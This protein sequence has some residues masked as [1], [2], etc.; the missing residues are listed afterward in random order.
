MASLIRRS[1][2]CWAGLVMIAALL[3]VLLPLAGRAVTLASPPFPLAQ[4]DQLLV[5]PVALPDFDPSVN[6]FQFS[7]AEMS[8]AINLQS[9]QEDW[10]LVLTDQ[11]QQLFGTQVC[12]GG[13]GGVGCVLTAAAQD[14]LNNQLNLMQQ[15]VGE[16][17]AAATLQLWQPQPRPVIP[18]WQALLNFILR[19]TVF[20]L[21]RN[22]FDLQTFIANLFLLQHV[23]QVARPTQQIRDSLTPTQILQEI[24]RA[25]V[26]QPTD[27]YTMGLYR[28]RDNRLTD[29]QSLTPYKVEPQPDGQYWV[30]VYDSNYPAGRPNGPKFTY[31]EFNPTTDSWTYQPT[32]T[33]TPIQGDATS[34]N[35]DL[36]KLSW[37]LPDVKTDTPPLKGPFTCPFCEPEPTPADVQLPA[38]Q[39]TIALIGEGALQVEQWD[40]ATA[41]YQPGLQTITGDVN[42]VPFKGGLDRQVPARYQLSDPES[43]QPLRLTVSGKPQAQTEDATLAITGPGYTASFEQ[44]RLGPND[45]LSLFLVPATT[46]PQITVTAPQAQTMPALVINLE[47]FSQNYRFD[48]STPASFAQTERRVSK[49]TQFQIGGLTLPADQQVALAVDTVQKRFYFGDTTANP[50]TYQ[51]TVKNVIVVQDRIQVGERQPDFINYTLSYDEALRLSNVTVAPQTQAFFDYQPALYDPGEKSRDQILDDLESRHI[52]V[53]IG[54]ISTNGIT[55]AD[56]PIVFNLATASGTARIYA[57]NLQ[58]KAML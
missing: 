29:G 49:S 37:R 39:I 19:R 53:P 48:S 2:W 25:L 6:G 43:N 16:G 58:L 51:V 4:A 32:A 21:A 50:Q 14:W 55:A 41:Q 23:D 36:S 9:R 56:G 38:D 45:Q 22:L 52:D 11:L 33:S 7:N 42:L 5:E 40:P 34:K 20:Q 35:L 18:W 17:M 13:A 54:S 8:Q 44:L 10:R 24:I 1:W 26:S 30:Y 47:D 28:R 46:G 12:T 3:A 31:V 57:G 27:P 15:G